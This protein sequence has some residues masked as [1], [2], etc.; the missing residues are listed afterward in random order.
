MRL[1]K[2]RLD[3]NQLDRLSDIIA[4]IALILF[5]ALVLPLFTP[6]IDKPTPLAVVFGVVVSFGL[7]TLSIYLAGKR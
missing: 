6:V 7:Y 5:G 4:N 1:K 2:I 3:R